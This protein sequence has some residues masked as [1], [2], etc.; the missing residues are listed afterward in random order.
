MVNDKTTE[1]A[2]E[3]MEQDKEVIEESKSQSVLSSQ[4]TGTGMYVDQGAYIYIS[5][6][7]WTTGESERM[8]Y[9]ETATYY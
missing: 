3:N 6:L 1:Q 4:D 2:A 9:L 8:Y 7:M 5:A